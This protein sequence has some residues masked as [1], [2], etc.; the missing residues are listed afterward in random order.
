MRKIKWLILLIVLFSCNHESS[1]HTISTKANVIE[2][3]GYSV[4]KDSIE[5]P[6]MSLLG[7]PLIVKSKIPQ[8]TT[9]APEG[10]K[11]KNLKKIQSKR[12]DICISGKYSFTLPTEVPANGIIVTAG[13]P[14]IVPAKAPYTKDQNPKNIVTYGLSQGLKNLNIDAIKQ[15]KEGN[16]WIGTGF[17][18]VCKFDG[19]NF[20]HYTEKQGLL[21]NNTEGIFI[22]S[23][24]NLWFGTYSGMSKFDG[25]NFVNYTSKSGLANDIAQFATEDNLGNIWI[26]TQN[27]L[28]C[29]NEQKKSILN[30]TKKN[31]LTGNSI[32]SILTD[33]N[34]KIW[35]GTRDNGIS[36][37]TM[38]SN[39]KSNTYTFTN[40]TTKQGLPSNSITN[41][42]EDELGNMWIA[43]INGL[44][45]FTPASNINNQGSIVN[46]TTD[47]GLLNN[48]ITDIYGNEKEEIWITTYSG[49]CV[50]KQFPSESISYITEKEGLPVNGI[51]SVFIDKFQNVWFGAEK[52]GISKYK[53]NGFNF[54][55]DTNIQGLGYATAIKEDKKGRLWIGT[56]NNG[57]LQYTPAEKDKPAT[58]INFTKKEGLSENCVYSLN[59]DKEDRVWI[60]YQNRGISILEVSNDGKNAEFKH[61]NESNGLPVGFIVSIMQDKEGSIWLGALNNIWPGNNGKD[62]ITPGGACKINGD[63]LYYYSEKQ[64]LTDKNIWTI[65]QDTKGDFWFGS[66]GKGLTRY[67]PRKATFTQF[68][69]NNGLLDNKVRPIFADS[70]GAIWCGGL[71]GN[72]M[73]KFETDTDGNGTIS[74][75]YITM[76]N[77]LPGNNVLSILEDKKG[78]LWFGNYY[79]IS[80]LSTEQ[81][82]NEGNDNSFTNYTPENGYQISICIINSICQSSDG[83]IWV[84]GYNKLSIFDP[85]KQNTDTSI[86]KVELGSISLF[87]EKIKWKKDTVF[88]LGNGI[89]IAGYDYKEL[90]PFYNIPQQLTLPYDANFISFQFSGI[91]INAPENIHYQYILEGLESNWN[92]TPFQTEAS[93][94]NLPPGDYVFKIRAQNGAGS[95]SKPYSLP[96]VIKS[97]WW[98]SWPAIL[99]YLFLAILAIYML[100]QLRVRRGVEK[101]EAVATLRTKISS[102]LHDDVGTILS[103]LAMQSQMLTYSAKEEQ[104]ESLL[105]LSYMSRDAMERMRDTVWAMDSRKDKYENL[106]DRMRDFAE[107]NLALKNMTHEFSVLDI[108]TKKFIDP[109]KRQAI[110]LI[111]KEAITNITKHSNGK[112][113][114][115]RFTQDKNRLLLLVHDNG[116]EQPASSSDGLGMSNMKMRAEKIGGAL[117]TKYD[118]GFWV[119]LVV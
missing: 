99:L 21:N 11:V 65:T 51:A 57:L 110:Y 49:V 20:S 74:A 93:Y 100:T 61:Y 59:I 36:V 87:N 45:K 118:E 35:I 68:T 112:H 119:E 116:K 43:S 37:L 82:N 54:L 13:F 5:P 56:Y 75:K 85:E 41:L 17:G 94:S 111:F 47:N 46:Y 15:D 67:Q 60:G 8:I 64:G 69:N 23:K 96:F 12:G 77:G 70:K 108:D 44:T 19:V 22:D 107:K 16:L 10:I 81:R 114:V 50:L 103:G 38:N 109:E 33:K 30:F 115:I 1:K 84:G 117:T 31:G 48:E 52:A 71:G 95:W 73:T 63:T 9:I 4:P 102:D 86:P 32:S 72:G 89:N 62:H 98:L 24:G 97:P 18:G 78:N 55:N 80:K 76:A 29:L 83:L 14:E 26:G 79:G 104:K 106:V 42:Y 113:V 91:N 92:N 34:G 2:I 39:N 53:E 90:S 3:K 6:K 105:E 7:K 101:V 88:N 40:Y 27:G 58:I 28:S 66:W 25:V